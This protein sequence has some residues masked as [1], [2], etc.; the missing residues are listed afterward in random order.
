MPP[1]GCASGCGV[2]SPHTAPTPPLVTSKARRAAQRSVLIRAR[3]R[4][5]HVG[6]LRL[7]AARRRQ[8]R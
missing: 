4:K 7:R 1:L 5:I 6:G 3:G 8:R 2:H